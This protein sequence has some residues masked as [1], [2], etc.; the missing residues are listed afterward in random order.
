MTS[1]KQ[2]P[3]KKSF[4]IVD[5]LEIETESPATAPTN[6]KKRRLSRD[7]S[8]EED[9]N[10]S[11]PTRFKY[12]KTCSES[13]AFSESDLNNSLNF[14]E[15]SQ[16][17]NSEANYKTLSDSPHSEFNNS[18]LYSEGEINCED[19]AATTAT[20][21]YNNNDVSRCS[22][23]YDSRSGSKSRS[24]SRSNSSSSSCNLKK[25]RKSRTAFSDHQ[26]N[27]LEKSFEKHKY[28]SVQD[29]VE[30]AA[31]LALTDTQVKTWYQ[32]RRSVEM[33][34]YFKQKISLQI[35]LYLVLLLMI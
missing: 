18:R 22:R 13:S 30:L 11:S 15:Y 9:N 8:D 21:D 23:S 33:K 35:F 7:N 12:Q 28:L 14:H 27:S 16:H 19:E 1:K 4:L 25:N 26:L 20:G 3:S 6:T 5:L 34:I 24:R 31:R 10:D 32:N 29:R 17:Q 2:Q